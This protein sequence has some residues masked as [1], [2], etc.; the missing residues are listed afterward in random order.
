MNGYSVNAGDH[1]EYL[2]H[3]YH[4]S[5]PTLYSRDFF[6]QHFI[7]YPHTVR[8]FTLAYLSILYQSSHFELLLFLS[9]FLC[10]LLSV[11]A[12]FKLAQLLTGNELAAYIGTFLIFLVFYKIT[13]G[14]NNVQ[15]TQFVSS[16]PAKALAALA[17]LQFFRKRYY[18][19]A[20]LLGIATLF[21][22][23]AGF[24]VFILLFLTGW[25]CKRINLKETLAYA[26][27]Y[28]VPA[29]F[30]IVP[31]LSGLTGTEPGVDKA[32]YYHSLFY[33]R[34]PFHYNPLTFPLKQYILFILLLIAAF[35]AG[36]SKQ[37]AN[38]RFVRRMVL[39]IL[40][41]CALHTL[42]FIGDVFHFF[43]LFQWFK[44]TIWAGAFAA[45][46]IADRISRLRFV[47]RLGDILHSGWLSGGL[48][49]ASAALLFVIL[50]SAAVPFYSF[51]DR[52]KIGHY[53][54]SDLSLMHR[55]IEANTPKDALFMSFPDDDSFLC[56]ARRSMP[57]H[58]RAMV[59]TPAYLQDWNASIKEI[60]HID[61]QLFDPKS[62][63]LRK[64]A[65]RLY[66][67]DTNIPYFKPVNKLNYKLIDTETY[68]CA[69]PDSQVVHM[70]GKYVLLKVG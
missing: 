68:C 28:L 12:F 40:V 9:S 54:P 31:M 39:C 11:Y 46:F 27:C 4:L 15:Y 17:I 55:W 6:V 16:T 59:H 52:Y 38:Y 45:I 37:T 10:I 34:N 58:F 8:D 53:Q 5:D 62:T 57:V 43:I 19:S 67:Q 35:A 22:M 3:I 44:M 7:Q 14:G 70:Q 42:C 25:L 1:E 23:L 64:E 61:V 29:A 69:Y 48:S 66:N 51:G 13:L 41:I 30:I 56:E 32:A 36:M 24:Q 49:L 50:N 33:V 2:P 21:Q 18:L 60:Y 47:E 20:G 65:G 26:F 63:T